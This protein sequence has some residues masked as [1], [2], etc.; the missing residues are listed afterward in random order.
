MNRKDEL[1][2]AIEKARSEL[3]EIEE[4][5]NMKASKA[6]VGKFFKYR[7]SY[8]CPKPNEY[9][10]LYTTVTGVTEEGNPLAWNFQ[11][12]IYGKVEV[13]SDMFRPSLSAGYTEISAQ[14]FWKAYDEIMFE[15][16]ARRPTKR[17][18][19]ARKSALKKVSSNKKGSAKPA[20]G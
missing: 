17:A 6:L 19:D 1:K 13:E 16:N 9:W 10:W 5:E 8:S 20:R 15:L 4:T 18:A 14:E 7:N 12:D 11:K 3:R 2:S